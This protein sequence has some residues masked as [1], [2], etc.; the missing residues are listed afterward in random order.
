MWVIGGLSK[1]Y[2]VQSV[3]HTFYPVTLTWKGP[4]APEHS[5]PDTATG[6][7]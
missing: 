2:C 3:G 6:I 7:V 1:A 4:Q 5:G